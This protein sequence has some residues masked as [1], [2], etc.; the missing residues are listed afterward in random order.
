MNGSRLIIAS[1][2]CGLLVAGCASTPQ[3]SED[4][5]AAKAAV[6][7]ARTDQRVL[8]F[9][10]MQ[11]Q[12]AEGNLKKAE[13]LLD[14][15]K[16]D[17]LMSHYAYLATR[18]AQTAIAMG[19]TG[20][21]K[22]QIESAD[23]ERDRA[24]LDAR[25]RQV[26]QANQKAQMAQGQADEMAQRLAEM[27]AKQTERGIV[28]TLQD[29]LFDTGRAELKSGASSTI[30]NLASFM[31]DYPDRRVRIEGFTDSTGSA[32]FNQQLSE[33]RALAVKDALV[34]AGIEANR[35]DVQGFGESNPV[36]SNDT[37]EGRQLNRRVEILI[38]DESGAIA[39]RS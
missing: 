26:D 23:A 21:V 32:E 6:T 37:N 10:P 2:S 18:E 9:A 19:E 7:Q 13:S 31:K 35:I 39:S 8:D 38:S 33:N 29:V 28:L 36:A 16:S 4:V 15:R 25:E 12:T 27:Q 11:L 24:R 1:L 17:V 14:D 3:H 22:K 5:V 20:A 30:I 34:L